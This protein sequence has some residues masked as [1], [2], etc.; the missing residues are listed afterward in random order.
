[1]AAELSRERLLVVLV[2]ALLL[3]PSATLSRERCPLAV[4]WPRPG[5]AAVLLRLCSGEQLGRGRRED[6]L[7][8]LRL[9]LV[10][11]W[12]KWGLGLPLPPC[13]L[14]MCLRTS[15]PLSLPAA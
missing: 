8:L 11:W 13:L 3:C 15:C 14:A 5:L 9:V 12:V 7:L 6:S 10:T 1:M 2:A 4:A